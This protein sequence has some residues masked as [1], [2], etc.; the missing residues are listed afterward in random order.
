MAEPQKLRMPT[1]AGFKIVKQ[2]GGGGFSTVYQAVHPET[3]RV[4]ACKVVTITPDFSDWQMKAIERECRVHTALKH[5]HILELLGAAKLS[6][7]QAARGGYLPAFYLLME[8]AA[9]GDLFDKIL[10]DVGIDEDISHY[11]FC[12]MIAGLSYLHEEGVCHRDLKPE[13]LLLD[14]AGTLKISDFGLCAVYK[15]K[16]T[17]KTRVLN[18]RCG[19]LPYIAPELRGT[20]S[21]EAEPIDVWGSGV[22]LF[23][24]LAGN[25]PWD[26][27]TRGS[28][29]FMQYITGEA[30]NHRPW[31]RFSADALSLITGMLDIEP[32]HRMTLADVA[33]HPW[34]ARPSQLASRGLSA[35]AASLTQGLRDSGQMF[36]AEPNLSASDDDPMEVDSAS[37]SS[38]DS[39]ATVRAAGPRPAKT[40]FTQTLMLFSQMPGGQRYRY[41]PHLTRFFAALLPHALLVLIQDALAE[42][43][44]KQN[45]AKELI[46][47]PGGDD[48]DEEEEEEAV[49]MIRMRIGTKDRR[50]IHMK[51][52]VEIEEMRGVGY[53]GS[54]VV[55]AR[56]AG[57]PLEWRA[58]WKTLVEHPLVSPHVYRKSGL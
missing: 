25:T 55:F 16:E 23:T 47:E 35:I 14:A 41:C 5:K 36:I 53:S 24:M 21:Y 51:G 54:F 34:V 28:V 31:N 58:M 11:Y 26:E 15:V 10:P 37:F 38:V 32:S 46:P 43:G 50:K 30:F 17:G 22:I 8:I 29:E 18:E 57:N 39:A 45:P 6:I 42:M 7:E 48:E 20:G 19:S 3:H 27:P 33:G 56:D 13:N 52:Y 2:I 40:Q 44:V 4:A 12:Q 49:A 9:G 1:V